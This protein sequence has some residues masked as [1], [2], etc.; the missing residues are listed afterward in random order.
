MARHIVLAGGGTAG[1]ISPLLATADALRRRDPGIGITALGTVKGLETRIVPERGYALEL[2]PAV[3]LPRKPSAELISV[4]GRLAGT[5]RR[6]AEILDEVGAD[7]VVGFGGYVALPAYLAARRRGLPI[8]VHE[9]NARP[10]LANR[11]GARVTPYVATAVPGSKLPHAQ[12]VGMPLRPAISGLDR[13]ALRA[14]A[15]QS[16]GLDP[17]RPTLF[18]TGGSQGARR[19]NESAIAAAPAFAAA[20][21]QVLHMYG[22]KNEVPPVHREAGE[23][24]YVALPYVDRIELAYAAADLMLGRCGMNTVAEVTAV[25]LPAVFVPLPIGN[26]EQR[27]N[28]QPVVAAGGGVLV[29]D[30]L[31]TAEWIAANLIPLFAEPE[32]LE[33]MGAAAAGLGRRDADDRLAD[34]VDEAIAASARS[35]Q[36][37]SRA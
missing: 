21:V 29:D 12:Y 22:R 18:V 35:D 3:P 32:T 1:H 20:G 11:I 9:A 30:S 27:L 17:D 6:T 25:G 28:A 2:I 36:K 7:A 10:G 16:F 4:P 37:G 8:I 33:K 19:I 13:A 31:L 5:I 24:P 26:G 34:L 14:E 15:R 23:P